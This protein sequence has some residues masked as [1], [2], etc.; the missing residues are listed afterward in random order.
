[1]VLANNALSN[2]TG[3][4]LDYERS[5]S[6]TAADDWPGYISG[7]VITGLVEGLEEGEIEVR[8]RDYD[9]ALN[10]SSE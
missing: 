7:N 2:P 10:E 5:G 6:D 3:Y 1:M 9:W 4:G 8:F